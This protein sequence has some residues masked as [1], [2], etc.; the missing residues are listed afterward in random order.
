MTKK[1]L[2]IAFASMLPFLAAC[3]GGDRTDLSEG[4]GGNGSS[5]TG[6]H[7]PKPDP[8]ESPYEPGS[9]G[10]DKPAFCDDFEVAHPGGR[11]GELDE[12]RWAFSRNAFGRNAASS[13]GDRDGVPVKQWSNPDGP[14]TMCGSEF[15]NLLP[16]D[17]VRVC[18]GQLNEVIGPEGLPINSFMARQLFDFTGR[19]GTIVF[20]VDAKRNDG[21]DGH[22]WWLEMWLTE[23]PEP[24][25][26]HGAPTVGS[27]P[28]N[29]I[30]FQIAPDLNAFDDLGRN[31]VTRFVLVKNH[32][33]IRDGFFDEIAVDDFGE[34]SGS[35]R[36]K[37]TRP[38][39]FK[40]K[41]SKDDI[42]VLVS[43]HDAP[44]QLRFKARSRGLDLPFTTGYVH[45]QH[46][47]YNPSK[48]PNCDCTDDTGEDC[49]LTACW[50]D[51]P[52]EGPEACCWA[53]PDGIFASAA[54]AY[55]WDNIGFD[56]PA[57]PA[58]RGHDADD[59]PQDATY[60]A[61]GMVIPAVQF[62]WSLGKGGASEKRTITVP[63]VDPSDAL[64]ATFN[65]S[66]IT[67]P[68]VVLRYRFNGN[69]WH[70]FQTPEEYRIEE[71]GEIMV[72]LRGFSLDI[73]VDELVSGANT[74]EVVDNDSGNSIGNV[75]ITIHPRR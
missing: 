19:T 54:Q 65:F 61:D 67:W 74:I 49:G 5:G 37:D 60:E 58:P 46:V 66:Y 34:E 30:G 3:G 31:A 22:G 68:G 57:Y 8:I 11:S 32:R 43:D 73:P 64:Y 27:Y 6:G 63:D 1:P 4:S 45:F 36:V 28:R 14:P 41:I 56:G 13:Y 7:R 51:P 53:N 62:G 55:R 12:R 20:D 44:G 23:D 17:D 10:L 70:E 35:F 71:D 15:T 18:A 69:A 33:I 2:R 24:I 48:T 39:K 26:Y 42:E 21:W 38:N 16:P 9:C 50:A 59:P 25:P 75:D 72:L 52:P 40:V 47:H 29:G